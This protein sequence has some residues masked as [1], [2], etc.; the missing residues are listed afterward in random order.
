MPSGVQTLRKNASGIWIRMPR[1]VA[2]QR[3]GADRAAMIQ[4]EQ[5]LQPLLDQIVALVTLDM[6]D[7]ADAAGVVLVGRVI[8]PLLFRLQY[9]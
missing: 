7:E 2:G 8:E 1:A 5:D 9:H 4:V 6:R 3:I